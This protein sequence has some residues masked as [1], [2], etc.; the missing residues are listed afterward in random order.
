MGYARIYVAAELGVACCTDVFRVRPTSNRARL[1]SECESFADL[2][3][4]EEG[5]GDEL[6]VNVVSGGKIRR[7]CCCQG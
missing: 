5:V 7:I 1:L 4:S 3:C 6:L 2:F